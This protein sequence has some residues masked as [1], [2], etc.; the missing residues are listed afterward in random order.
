MKPALIH[1]EDS[2]KARLM[3]RSRR[4]GTSFS[5]EV[6]QAVEL[7][8]ALPIES[9]EE[10]EILSGE[11]RAATDRMIKKMDDTI[12]RVDLI[13]RKSGKRR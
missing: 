3:K 8:L 10:L 4:S 9:R 7:Y 1:L 6:R 13:L 12:E 11:A 5:K 2:Q